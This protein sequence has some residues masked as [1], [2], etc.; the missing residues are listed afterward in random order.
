MDTNLTT[1]HG[2][3]YGNKVVRKES[4]LPADLTNASAATRRVFEPPTQFSS[5]P[6]KDKRW[7]SARLINHRVLA[8]QCTR[9]HRD[10]AY[11]HQLDL[12]DVPPCILLQ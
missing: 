6:S 5:K 10:Y 8:A 3:V 12:Y 9:Q 7:L 11:K 4:D 1:F 2:R